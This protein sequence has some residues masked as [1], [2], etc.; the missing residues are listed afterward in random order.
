M[1]ARL[2]RRSALP[3]QCCWLSSTS[4][5]TTVSLQRGLATHATHMP[6]GGSDKPQSFIEQV[7][8]RYAV[9]LKEG[10]RVLAGDYVSI[11]PG[12]VMTH[13]NTGP[14]ISK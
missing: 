2:L 13:D 14:C 9:D 5:P 3:G 6:T 4:A 10:Q 1:A 12:Q 7:V 11:R 8:Q